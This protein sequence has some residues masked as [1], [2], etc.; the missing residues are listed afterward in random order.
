MVEDVAVRS[1]GVFGPASGVVLGLEPCTYSNWSG[2]EKEGRPGPGQQLF[3]WVH[4][5][6]EGLIAPLCWVPSCGKIFS[7]IIR[8]HRC[9]PGQRVRPF[10]QDVPED[11]S[12]S[13]EV[14]TSNYN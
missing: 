9:L 3:G 2:A 5:G 14:V 1:C 13:F 7:S 6:G 10:S 8:A 4:C 12:G 11:D